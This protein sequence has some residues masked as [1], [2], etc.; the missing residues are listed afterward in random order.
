M[1]LDSVPHASLD[2]IANGNGDIGF[3]GCPCSGLG[4]KVDGVL[5]ASL[6]HLVPV[7]AR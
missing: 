1:S 6:A 3:W 2:R 7:L 5:W 4:S